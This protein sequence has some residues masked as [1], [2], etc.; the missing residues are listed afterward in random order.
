MRCAFKR[1]VLLPR[2]HGLRNPVEIAPG[3]RRD[4]DGN[5]FGHVIAMHVSNR[6]IYSGETRSRAFEDQENFFSHV[7]LALPPVYR[8][9][10]GVE[11]VSASR[12]FTVHESAADLLSLLD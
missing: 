5:D 8:V 4:R 12:Q 3:A 1:Y 9:N 10:R 7:H 6:A 11:N 2:A